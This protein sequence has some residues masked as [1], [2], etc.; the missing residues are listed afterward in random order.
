MH[1]KLGGE[2]AELLTHT[3][4]DEES[5]DFLLTQVSKPLIQPATSEILELQ[6][7]KKQ[8]PGV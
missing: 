3:L 6:T 8:T 5:A 4:G 1:G 7:G 2:V